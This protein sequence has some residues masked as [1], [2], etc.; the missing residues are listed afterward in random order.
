[1][2]GGFKEEEKPFL[3]LA[4]LNVKLRAAGL[5]S[6]KSMPMI[7]FNQGPNGSSV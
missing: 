4:G 1:M 3:S 7:Q 5:D 6:V 2:K